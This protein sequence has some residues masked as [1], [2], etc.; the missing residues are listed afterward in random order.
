MASAQLTPNQPTEMDKIK[1]ALGDGVNKIHQIESMVLHLLQKL[2]RQKSE[3]ATDVGSTSPVQTPQGGHMN[4]LADQAQAINRASDRTLE[5][6]Q[7]LHQT[8]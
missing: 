1:D 8:L 6:L 4:I 7:Q 3:P 5:A 2:G